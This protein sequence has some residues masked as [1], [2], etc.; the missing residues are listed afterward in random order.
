MNHKKAYITEF[1]D[2]KKDTMMNIPSNIAEALKI[3]EGTRLLIVA[4]INK[5]NFVAYP[6]VKEERMLAEVKVRMLDKPGALGEIATALGEMG[7]NIHTTLIPPSTTGVSD[8]YLIVDCTESKVP[9]T[10]VEEKLG[11][12]K[13]T[14]EV[15]VN[16]LE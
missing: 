14:I 6:I 4:D 3:K 2:V 13:N 15:E 11:K 1:V 8:A 10:E 5:M 12:L 9:L 16:P 7:I